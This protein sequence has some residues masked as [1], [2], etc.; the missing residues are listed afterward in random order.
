MKRFKVRMKIKRT[1]IYYEGFGQITDCEY[2]HIMSDDYAATD[3]RECINS[4]KQIFGD[5]IISGFVADA[6]TKKVT[7]IKND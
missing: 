3:A 7:H 5:E 2:T 1:S 6:D 4:L